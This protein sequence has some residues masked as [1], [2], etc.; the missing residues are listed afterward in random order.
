MHACRC[1]AGHLLSTPLAAAPQR[2]GRNLVARICRGVYGP[3]AEFATQ[4]NA[5]ESP[6]KQDCLLAFIDV[7]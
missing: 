6:H 7:A 2:S 5:A 4:N 1:R 3:S